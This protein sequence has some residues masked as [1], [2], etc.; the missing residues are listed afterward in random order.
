MLENAFTIR[1]IETFY[2][3]AKYNSITRAASKLNMS[4]PAAW[5]HIHNLETLYDKIFF[6]KQGRSLTLT[7]A[8]HVLLAEAETFL[9]A[10]YRLSNVLL[11]ISRQQMPIKLSITNTFQ[12]IGFR[13]IKPFLESL[14]EVRVEF[15]LDRWIDQQ[16]LIRKADH[17]FF[18]LGDPMNIPEYY[19]QKTLLNTAHAL[20][21]SRAHPISTKTRLN[22]DD[23]DD[24]DYVTTKT[25]SIT[26]SK[27]MQQFKNWG[28]KKS[29]IYVDSFLAVKEAV[30][31]NLG[32]ALLPR[33]I[34][35]EELQSGFMCALPIDTINYLSELRLI[36]NGE[37]LTP[38]SH[39]LFF[40]FCHQDHSNDKT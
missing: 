21:A 15:T 2:Y 31:A 5:K 9:S 23:I 33:C 26:Q 19:P 7:P 1:Q 20:V 14:P 32:I 13:L 4:P 30:L 28:M 6:E 34:V 40:N 39:S 11:E 22:I 35:E 18:I 25:R 36:Y 17:D 37:L 3:T 27:Y 24:L 12:R 38:G 16:Q 10:R 29:P 8:G